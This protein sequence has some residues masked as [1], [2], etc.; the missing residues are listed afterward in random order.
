MCHLK[1]SLL[2]CRSKLIHRV[3]SA[4]KV[5]SQYA[6]WSTK[7]GDNTPQLQGLRGYGHYGSGDKRSGHLMGLVTA[8]IKVPVLIITAGYIWVWLYQ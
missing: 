4:R 2:G 8:W 3:E 5:R 7:L 1:V 6:L